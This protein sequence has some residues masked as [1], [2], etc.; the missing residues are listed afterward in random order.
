MPILAN[1]IKI[2][3]SKV[4]ADVPEGGGGP[5]GATI[6]WG[7][8]NTLFDDVD[9][10]SRTIGN[11]SIRQAF[12]HVD[13]DNTDRLLG[14]YAMVAKLP[15]DPNVSVT[16]AA[17]APFARR[18][19]ISDAIANYLTPGVPW[20]GLL[21]GNHVQGQASLQF[22]A[23][24]AG[25]EPTVG[26]TLVLVIDEGLP[27]ERMEWVRVIKVKSETRTFEDDRGQYQVFV[28]QCDLANGLTQAVPGSDPNREFLRAPGAAIMRDTT[29]ANAANYYGAA[30]TTALAALGASSV[31]T[32]SVYGQL[33][34]SSATPQTALDQRPAAQRTLT[35]ASSPRAVEVATAVHTR[36]TLIDQENRGLSYVFSLAPVPEPSSITITWVGLGNR[37]SLVDDGAGG[38]SGAGAGTVTYSTGSIALTLPSLPDLGSAVVVTWAE[39]LAYTDRSAQ[40]VRVR[41]PEYVFVVD[42]TDEAMVE[43]A[44]LSLSYTSGGAVKTCTTNAAGTIAGDGTGHVDW[45]S[46]TVQFRP[47]AMPDPGATIACEYEL[48]TLTTDII[49]PSLI[50]PDSSGYA[51]FTLSKTPAAGT[52]E[53]HWATMQEVKSSSGGSVSGGSSKNEQTQTT[54]VSAPSSR[55]SLIYNQINGV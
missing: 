47:A 46:G 41:R 37:Q 39:R 4:M 30:P 43:P 28:V 9:T 50:T 2:R 27:T 3:A 40:G 21:M 44:S 18:S 45:P 49:D 15:A 16:L 11:V 1:D 17:C 38:L 14:A 54:Q 35:L 34:P 7:Q 8:S 24:F 5:S 53:I 31:K 51:H 19:Q 12:L 10:V 42:G 13:T 32:T 6:A 20:N 33:V 25:V 26:R 29:T 48:S 36:R 55:T 52:V 22:Y 23:R